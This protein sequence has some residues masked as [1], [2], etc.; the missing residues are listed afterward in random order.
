MTSNKITAAGSV[1]TVGGMKVE[2]LAGNPKEPG[3]CI[4]QI[5][6]VDL[7]T[8]ESM[9]TRNVAKYSLHCVPHFEN[10]DLKEL[11]VRDRSVLPFDEGAWLKYEHFEWSVL[12]STYKRQRYV[13]YRYSPGEWVKYFNSKAEIEDFLHKYPGSGMF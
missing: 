9:C 2:I 6:S 12:P 7:K 11:L 1:I 5:Q 3:Q 13:C 4:C 10:P 8:I